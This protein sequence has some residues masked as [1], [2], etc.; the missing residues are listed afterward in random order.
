MQSDLYSASSIL[1]IVKPIKNIE[2][3]LSHFT[4]QVQ[5]ILEK[6]KT[7]ARENGII[8]EMIFRYYQRETRNYLI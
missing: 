1:I 8:K 7:E 5:I 3:S 6:L 4:L 2:K